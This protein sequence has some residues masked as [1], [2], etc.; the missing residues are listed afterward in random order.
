MLHGAQGSAAACGEYRPTAWA[1]ASEGQVWTPA[2]GPVRLDGVAA[3]PGYR[4]ETV[5]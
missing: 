5:C 1:W 4:L 3:E 2:A